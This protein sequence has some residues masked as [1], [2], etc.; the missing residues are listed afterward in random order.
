MDFRNFS[1]YISQ[2]KVNRF[3]D[4]LAAGRFMA[5]VCKKCGKKYYPPLADCSHCMQSDMEWRQINGRGILG[6]FTK[7]Y[8]PP[9]HFAVRQP[10]MPFSSIQ[11]EPCP[12]GLLEVE[13]GLRIM[14]WIPKVDVKKIKVGMKMK[15]SPQLLPDGKITIVLEPI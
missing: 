2:I 6:T 13:D 1:L 5:T 4:E 15:A 8:V 10:L 11:F 9:D 7:I 3:V 14:G 12:I